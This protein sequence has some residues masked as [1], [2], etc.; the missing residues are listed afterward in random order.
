MNMNAQQLQEAKASLKKLPILGPALWLFARD[1]R[2][3]F[4][5][6]ADQ[7][8]LVMPPLILDQCKLYMKDEIPWAFCTWAFVS[9]QVDERLSSSIPK[10]APHEWKSGEHLWLIDVVAPFGG[11]DEI[12]TDL[13]KTNFAGKAFKALTPQPNGS[14]IVENHPAV[15]PQ[16]C[17]DES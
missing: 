14:F 17:S 15:A 4:T 2:K 6:I 16:V 10:I 13:Q 12:I 3:K 1:E 11:A 9:D 8:W 7:D 5:F